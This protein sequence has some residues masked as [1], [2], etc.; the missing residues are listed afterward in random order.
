MHLYVPHANQHA[1]GFYRRLGFTELPAAD[2]ELPV[3]GPYLFAMDL[4]VT[5]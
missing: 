3:P 4:P 5:P 2:T 1:A